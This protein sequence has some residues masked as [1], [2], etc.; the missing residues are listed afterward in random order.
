MLF[1]FIPVILAAAGTLGYL[2]V[3]DPEA[4]QSVEP[5]V[6]EVSQPF[7]GQTNSDNKDSEIDI[8]NVQDSLC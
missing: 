1:A 8:G 2:Q 3:T 4:L 7:L 5:K 6:Q